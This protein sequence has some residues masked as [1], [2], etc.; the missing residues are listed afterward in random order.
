VA[1]CGE[2]LNGPSGTR[3]GRNFCIGCETISFSL[4]TASSSYLVNR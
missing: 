4:Q 1:D 2:Q 3:G